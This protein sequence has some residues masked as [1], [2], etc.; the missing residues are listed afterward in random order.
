MKTLTRGNFFLDTHNILNISMCSNRKPR[1]VASKEKTGPRT[2]GKALAIADDCLC[3]HWGCMQKVDGGMMCHVCERWFHG[4]CSNLI[5]VE[6]KKISRES[7]RA[8]YRQPFQC[9][10]GECNKGIGL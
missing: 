3:G 5:T 7:F 9:E 8:V 4:P 1:L 6:Y 2:R 10:L